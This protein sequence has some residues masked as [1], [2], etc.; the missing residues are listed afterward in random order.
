MSEPRAHRDVQTIPTAEIIRVLERSNGSSALEL[1]V[2]IEG[3]DLPIL[4]PLDA[5]A[6][7]GVTDQAAAAELREVRKT[8]SRIEGAVPLSDEIAVSLF[9]MIDANYRLPKR[10]TG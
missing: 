6:S 3:R 8:L 10:E 5:L 9:A 2:N 1:R 4:L 7:F